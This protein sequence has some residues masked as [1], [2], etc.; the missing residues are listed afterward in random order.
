MHKQRRSENTIQILLSGDGMKK[1]VLVCD[2]CEKMLSTEEHNTVLV[3]LSNGKCVENDLC[4]ECIDQVLDS[5][6][7]DPQ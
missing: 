1:N 7:G 6:S 5:V 4:N 3:T 2:R